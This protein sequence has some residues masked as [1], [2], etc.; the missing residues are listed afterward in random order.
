MTKKL[1]SPVL[2]SVPGV[3]CPYTLTKESVVEKMKN[4]RYGL[5]KMTLLDFPGKVACTVFTCGCNF[6]C[7]FCHNASLV[8]GRNE[9]MELS[10]DELFS[11]LE[12]RR[13]LL[14]GVAITGGEPLLHP[15]VRELLQAVKSLGYA[16]KLDTNGSFPE[17]LAGLIADKLVDYVAMDV[18]SSMER[19]ELLCGRPGMEKLIEKSIEILLKGEVE[20]EFRTTVVEELHEVADIESAAKLIAGAKRYFLQ[21][22]VETEDLLSPWSKFSGPGR[23]KLLAMLA[24]AQKYVPAAALRGVDL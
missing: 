12:K 9:D 23:E 10:F 11:F 22:F 1:Y 2:I 14:D 17:V 19:Y 20:Y 4:M 24:A 18:K 13:K 5:R 15:G 7:P 3:F 21:N 16:V 6:R 8:R